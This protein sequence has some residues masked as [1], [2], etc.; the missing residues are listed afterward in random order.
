MNFL[1]LS[2]QKAKGGI[3]DSNE[4]LKYKFEDTLNLTTDFCTMVL[5]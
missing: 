3:I 2:K 4:E 5:L 1:T